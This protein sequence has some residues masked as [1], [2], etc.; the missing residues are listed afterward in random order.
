VA[1]PLLLAVPLPLLMRPPLRRRPRRVCYGY[2]WNCG[3]GEPLLTQSVEKEESDE[4][5]GFGL[6][7]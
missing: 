5:M 4:D 6:F 1:P 7:D 2:P 3:M